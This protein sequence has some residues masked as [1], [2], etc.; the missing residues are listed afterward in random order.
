MEKQTLDFEQLAKDTKIYAENYI[1]LIRFKLIKKTSAIA[2]SFVLYGTIILF[3]LITF[4]LLSIGTAFWVG[5]VLGAYH[6]GF[7]IM[8]GF[9]ILISIILYTCRNKWIK[10][11]VLNFLIKN[12]SK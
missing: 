5:K 7:F 6:Y 3:L 1:Q 4:L 9:F 10:I 8:G 12:I 11:P 2:S